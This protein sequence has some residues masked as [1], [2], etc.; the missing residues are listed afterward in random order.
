MPI[1]DEPTWKLLVFLAIFPFAGGL[2]AFILSQKLWG[3]FAM[4]VTAGLI[5]GAVVSGLNPPSK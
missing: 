5:I 1:Q 3:W 4:L 2:A